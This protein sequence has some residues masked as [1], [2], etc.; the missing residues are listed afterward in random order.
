M[1]IMNPPAPRTPPRRGA[2]RG[3]SQAP[4]IRSMD[5]WQLAKLGERLNGS[6]VPGV[7]MT[8]REFVDW[9]FDNVNAEWVDG[10]VVLMAPVSDGHSDLDVWVGSLIQHLNE[11]LQLGAVRRDM[12]IRLARSKRL[13]VPDLMFI[14]NSRLNRIRP[15]YINGAPDLIF[16]IVSLD[17]RNRDR[18][19]KYLEYEAGGVREYW[20][21]D[22]MAQSLDGYTLKGRKYEEIQPDEDRVHSAVLPGFYL[23]AKWL[24]GKQRPKVVQVLKEFG[25][26]G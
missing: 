24:F 10:E 20:I 6:P 4:D 17:S 9:V 23:R 25:I 18:R 8:E 3:R 1:T 11:S 12:L 16:E 15:T 13:R 19:D 7:R 14:S 5:E 2:G 22:P 26:K 21:I